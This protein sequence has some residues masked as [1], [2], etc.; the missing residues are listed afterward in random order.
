MS[1][2]LRW[3]SW[4]QLLSTRNALSWEH[5]IEMPHAKTEK[6]LLRLAKTGL[7]LGP[8]PAG[9]SSSDVPSQQK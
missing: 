3:L 5:P 4:R 9:N 2:S 8:T 7:S 6:N 1:L